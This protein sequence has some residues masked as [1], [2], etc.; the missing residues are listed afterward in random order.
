MNGSKTRRN[1][2]CDE[3]TGGAFQLARL[4]SN[5]ARPG[6]DRVCRSMSA[7]SL[8]PNSLEPKSLEPNSLEPNSLE[9][10]SL[11]AVVSRTFDDL[12]S[13]ARKTA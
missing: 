13:H 1:G 12:P 11:G 7:N 2:G 6:A 4:Y 3:T 8:E 10:K 5:G 9:P